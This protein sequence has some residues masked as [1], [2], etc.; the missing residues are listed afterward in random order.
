M[1]VHAGHVPNLAE[2]VR[3]VVGNRR[4]LLPVEP[5]FR[6]VVPEDR[7]HVDPSI[8]KLRQVA[9][10]AP[11]AERVVHLEALRRPPALRD[12]DEVAAVMLLHRVGSTVGLE[13]HGPIGAERAFNKR[14][15]NRLCHL[16]VERAA[17]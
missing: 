7:Q 2:I 17:P 5:P 16:Y 14:F 12:G 10:K 11:G 4:D 3:R 6:F 1:A 13:A 9:S 15:A 8:G